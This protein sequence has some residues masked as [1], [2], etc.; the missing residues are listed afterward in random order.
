MGYVTGTHPSFNVDLG[1]IETGLD[2]ASDRGQRMEPIFTEFFQWAERR[3]VPVVLAAGNHIN[4]PLD[5][6]TPQKFGTATNNIITV[7]GVM[8]DGSLYENTAPDH[9]DRDGSMSVFAPAENVVAPGNGGDLH[10]DAE[11]NTGTSQAAAITISLP[12]KKLALSSSVDV[13]L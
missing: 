13:L 10:E 2:V 1:L 3:G 4:Q 6:G 5:K 7:G 8:E 12:I 11:S 9:P